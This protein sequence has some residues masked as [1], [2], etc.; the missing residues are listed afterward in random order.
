MSLRLKG[1]TSGYVELEAPAT[2]SNNTL[3]LPDG[4]GTSGQYLQTNGSGALSW[5]TNPAQFQSYAILQDQ[6]AQNTGGGT[7]TAGAWQTRD[8]NTEV[9]D[10]DGIVSLSTNQFTLI[11]GTY[12]IHWSAPAYAVQ[13]HQSILYDVTGVAYLDRGTSAYS[14]DAGTGQTS[15]SFGT[16]RVTISSSNTYEIRHRGTVTHATNGFGIETNVT[17]PEV[18]TVVEIYKEL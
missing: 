11:A 18:Y 16:A 6:K 12:L 7:F 17:T 14:R 5:T 3:T 10:P 9:F 4:N 2:S 15:R 1:S 13:R 8:L